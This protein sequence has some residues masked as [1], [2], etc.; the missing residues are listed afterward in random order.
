[1]AVP[2]VIVGATEH[3][4]KAVIAGMQPDY[5]GIVPNFH[6]NKG[7]FLS[8]PAVIL[9]CT[10][11]QAASSEIPYILRGEAPPSQ[12]STIA[13]GNFGAA[14]K[15]VV[16]GGAWSEEDVLS[17]QS[18][19][20][21]A[22]G[23]EGLVLLMKDAGRPEPPLGPTYGKHIVERVKMTM[24]EVVGGRGGEG[25]HAGVVWY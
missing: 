21:G 25:P 12:S 8:N 20:Q 11:I 9:F 14:P 13:S 4:G 6:T 22:R 1:M 18:A 24:G 2:I 23:S 16:F 19:L 3:I 15:A 5:E 10:S 7:S 17:V